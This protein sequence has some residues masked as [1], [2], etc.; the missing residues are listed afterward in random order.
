MKKL[1]YTT[2]CLAVLTLTSACT[3]EHPKFT[4]VENSLQQA[5]DEAI[6]TTAS[7]MA[8]PTPKRATGS[9]WQQ[10][11]NHF[12]KDPRAANVGDIVTVVV[13]ESTKAEV[14]AKTETD[15]T[16]S[17]TGGITNLLNL[18]DELSNIGI[19]PGVSGL[20]D[21]DSNRT[22]AGD[23]ST[24]REDTLSGKIAAVVT[25]LLPNGYLVIKGRREVMVNYELQEMILT[26]I[27]RP[28]DISPNNT[29]TS[30]KIA[31]ARIAYAG[32]GLVDEAQTP[33]VGVKWTDKFL[34][35]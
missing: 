27:I 32:K 21:T 34:P 9:L 8:Q 26:G 35:F 7:I 14:E 29:I 4:P 22:F 2:A 30:D 18:E 6:M 12:F 13:N 23:A 11:S 15:R 33:P 3:V 10:G 1:T 17:G 19:P 25:Q 5:M 20:F 28:A 16:H 31:E 24:D